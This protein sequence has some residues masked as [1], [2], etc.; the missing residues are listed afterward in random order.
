MSKASEWVERFTAVESDHPRT[1][2]KF[3]VPGLGRTIRFS[4]DYTGYPA[5][6]LDDASYPITFYDD[7]A[8][9]VQSARWI[10]D[11]FG[12]PGV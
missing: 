1:D 2:A 3:Y 9:L 10:L 8:G 6:S 11:T 12:E 5:I 7:I 4:V